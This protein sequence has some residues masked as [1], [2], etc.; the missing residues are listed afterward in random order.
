M[1]HGQ[2]R[3]S[4]FLGDLN[5]SHHNVKFTHE[6]FKE[7]IAFLDLKVKLLDGKISTDLFV[8]STDCQQFLHYTSLHPKSLNKILTKNLYLL[9]MDKEVK[10]VFT[11]KPI[12]S[13]RS[14]RKLSNYLVRAKMYPIERTAGSK[15]CG[16]KCCKVCMN[17]NETSTFTSTVTGETFIINQKFDCYAS[18]LVYLLTCRKCGS[19]L[20]KM[21]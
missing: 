3:I 13:F 20:L 4:S 15:N 14:D 9:H 11:L 16:S 21:K 12:I 18:C 5:K 19:I 7:D 17:V 1:P 6:T 2:E 10:K 8:K